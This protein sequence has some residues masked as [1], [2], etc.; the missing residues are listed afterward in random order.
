MKT[1]DLFLTNRVL[2]TENQNRILFTENHNEG[3]GDLCSEDLKALTDWIL[4]TGSDL[5]DENIEE[6]FLHPEGEL[7]HILL[8]ERILARFP[9]LLPEVYSPENFKFRATKTERAIRSQFFFATGLFDRKGK[10]DN[11]TFE[12]SGGSNSKS[13]QISDSSSQ[14]W[15]IVIQ[16]RSRLFENL[17]LV[18]LDHFIYNHSFTLNVKWFRLATILNDSFI[19]LSIQLH[20]LLNR[21]KH[22]GHYTTGQMDAVLF[23]QALV[24]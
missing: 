19:E 8:A 18:S 1:F 4:R 23:S 9:N 24:Q 7:E 5:Q 13:V 12:Y 6:K 16:F 20:N 14:I 3:R 10:L 21:P 2:F 15:F 17:T 11:S 22:R